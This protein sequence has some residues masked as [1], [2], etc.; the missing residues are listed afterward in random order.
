MEKSL[1]PYGFFKTFYKLIVC[2]ISFL[3]VVRFLVRM[4]G[5]GSYG[6][7]YISFIINLLD[8]TWYDKVNIAV[9]VIT[10]MA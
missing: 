8:Y 9:C 7:F 6:L 2:F 1:I 4:C 3:I 10:W 5:L